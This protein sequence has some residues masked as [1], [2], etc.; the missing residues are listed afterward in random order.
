MFFILRKYQIYEKKYVMSCQI[1]NAGQNFKLAA[2]MQF[3]AEKSTE[4]PPINFY[5]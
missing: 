1:Q 4:T 3:I 5:R 2:N